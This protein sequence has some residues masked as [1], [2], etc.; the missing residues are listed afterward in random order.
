MDITAH[1]RI[2]KYEGAVDEDGYPA[3][4]TDGCFKA[5]RN[6]DF[7]G[8]ADDVEDGALYKSEKSF[9]FAA[10]SYSGYSRWREQLAAMFGYTPRQLWDEPLN[11][12]VPFY[13]LLCFADNEGIIGAE[14]SAKLAKDFA[15]HQVTADAHADKWFRQKYADWRKAFELA[16]DGGAVDFH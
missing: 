6:P 13:E 1:S 7:P 12:G 16:A 3:D 8:R 5:W 11:P 14:V 10:G 9:W 2:T 15:T 4:G